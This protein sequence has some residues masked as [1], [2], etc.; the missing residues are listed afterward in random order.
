MNSRINKK[1][2]LAVITTF[3]FVNFFGVIAMAAKHDNNSGQN[4]VKVSLEKANRDCKST[5]LTDCECIYECECDGDRLELRIH[6]YNAQQLTEL[7]VKLEENL[8]EEQKNKGKYRAQNLRM[9]IER[10]NNLSK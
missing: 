6:K 2:L 1:L 9:H 8:A 4:T 5:R 7:A 10:I 3:V